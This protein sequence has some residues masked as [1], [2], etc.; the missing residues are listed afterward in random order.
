MWI[1]AP[2]AFPSYVGPLSS[3]THG[4]DFSWLIGI[5]VG[6]GLY[7]GLAARRVQDEGEAAAA[8]AVAG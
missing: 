5:V 6:A 3:H 2:T 7:W 8:P 4:S 1:N